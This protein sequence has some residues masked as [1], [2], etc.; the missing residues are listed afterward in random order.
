MPDRR[1]TQ[2]EVAEIFLTAAQRPQGPALTTT[3][4]SE[5]MTLAELQ[6]IGKEVGLAPE[7]VAE[8][9][10]LLQIHGRGKAQTFLGLPIGVQRAVA[11][12]RWLSDAEWERLVVE[13]RDAFNAK[14]RVQS[15]GSL[16]EWTN[17]NLQALLEPTQNG[18]R[19]RLRTV[20]GGA[21]TSIT[22]GIVALAVAGVVAVSGAVSGQL[23]QGLVDSL[24]WVAAG[25]GAIGVGAIQLPSWAR[26]RGRQMEEIAL[27][28]SAKQVTELAPSPAR[29]E[30]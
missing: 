5:G 22:I 20:K 24:T 8:A 9:A 17:G 11:L 10:H 2:D 1:Y 26:L 7:A 29:S 19:L 23:A 25:L 15:Y 28:L 6:E 18:H 13:L 14:G 3:E 16:R 30:K 12:N 21:R 27:R 4:P